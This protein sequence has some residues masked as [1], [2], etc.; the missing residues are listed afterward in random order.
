ML[1]RKH[2]NLHNR[3][4]ITWLSCY[5]MLPLITFCVNSLNDDTVDQL[6]WLLAYL[7]GHHSMTGSPKIYS[8]SA[9]GW[10]AAVIAFVVVVVRASLIELSTL[11]M[12]G[13]RGNFSGT[14]DSVTYLL[15]W[16]LHLKWISGWDFQFTFKG[17]Q[18]NIWANTVAQM[19]AHTRVG[20]SN[21]KKQNL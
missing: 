8:I 17:I 20:L 11:K 5:V 12:V 14:P 16:A 6:V 9:F 1:R 10:G 21:W 7:I 3:L 15:F 18:I 13:R 19:S 2:K 4:S